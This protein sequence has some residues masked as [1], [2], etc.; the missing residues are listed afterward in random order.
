MVLVI[1]P[2][3]RGFGYIVFEDG[4]NPI[5]WG[6]KTVAKPV[7]KNS[8]ERVRIMLHIYNPDVV[9]VENYNGK[10]SHRSKRIK[11]LIDQITRLAEQK[12]IKTR[13]YSRGQIQDCLQ[14]RQHF[15]CAA[16]VLIE[17]DQ[18]QRRWGNVER[19]RE[20]AA[21][22]IYEQIDTTTCEYGRRELN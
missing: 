15:E 11:R 17:F 19:L 1:A 12:N 13:R 4:P 16:V 20:T 2:V 8:L 10:G 22:R 7:N 5:D 14:L 6:I 3:S 21:N 9:I 18:R